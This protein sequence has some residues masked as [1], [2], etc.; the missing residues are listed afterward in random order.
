MAPTPT[1]P[2]EAEGRPPLSHSKPFID[3]EDFRAV[4]EALANGRIAQ[5][6]RENEFEFRT[7]HEVRRH[8]GVATRSGTGALYPA[9][10]G[11]EVHKGV[12]LTLRS[13]ACAA[14]LHSAEHVETR[15]V[16]VDYESASFNAGSEGPHGKPMAILK[17]MEAGIAPDMAGS[18]T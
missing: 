5:A 7:A 4:T 11:T 6:E 1:S 17:A 3:S 15:P 16:R 12:A 13:H 14:L 8:V 18:R 9:P 10:L 2:R